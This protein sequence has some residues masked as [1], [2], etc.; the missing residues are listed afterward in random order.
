MIYDQADVQYA[1]WYR[2]A[3]RNHKR[4]VYGASMLCSTLHQIAALLFD[5]FFLFPSKL[6]KAERTVFTILNTQFLFFFILRVGAF[7]LFILE[8]FYFIISSRDLALF[9]PLTQMTS[10]T[11]PIYIFESVTK[12]LPHTFAFTLLFHNNYN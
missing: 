1:E 7:H 6:S 9:L 2:S 8:K 10:R 12:I 3:S 4:C 11:Q 5:S